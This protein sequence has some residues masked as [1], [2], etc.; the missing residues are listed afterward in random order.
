MKTPRFE[1][2]KQEEKNPVI[3][4]EYT[5]NDEEEEIT[6]IY[7]EILTQEEVVIDTFMTDQYGDTFSEDEYPG[8]LKEVQDFLFPQ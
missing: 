6:I 8:L 1:L 4:R 7:T 5:L 2:L 3:V